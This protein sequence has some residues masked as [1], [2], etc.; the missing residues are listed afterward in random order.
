MINLD[1]LISISLTDKELAIEALK[2]CRELNLIIQNQD[3]QLRD[4]TERIKF[5]E[6]QLPTQSVPHN[7]QDPKGYENQKAYKTS[8]T[9]TIHGNKNCMHI[10][11]VEEL[12]R[13]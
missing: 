2:A 3:E 4:L 11:C 12:N 13:I 7:W 10:Y 5:L 1:Y 6:D 8:R 9:C